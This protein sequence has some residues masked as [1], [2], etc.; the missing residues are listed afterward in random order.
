MHVS[1]LYKA[2]CFV[3]FGL[4]DLLLELLVN[5]ITG[6]FDG[7]AHL[8]AGSHFQPERP[9]QVD[10]PDGRGGEELAEGFFVL[11]GGWGLV[12]LPIVARCQ[13]SGPAEGADVGERENAY[14]LSFCVSGASLISTFSFSRSLML[15]T[16]STILLLLRCLV[17]FASDGEAGASS[18]AESILLK[19]AV[20]SCTSAAIVVIDDKLRA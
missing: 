6:V 4:T 2:R 11:D 13:L 20:G 7:D 19:G 8:V 17:G 16:P 14:Q 1:E 9:F 18:T 3:H 15:K 10:L 12:Q 5:G